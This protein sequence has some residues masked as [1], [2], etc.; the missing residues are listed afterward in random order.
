MSNSLFDYT[1]YKAYLKQII[2]HRGRGEK[3]RIS[4]AL[5]CHI[6]YVSQVLN[7]DANFSL[8][9]ADSLNTYLSHTE[10]ESEFFLLLVSYAR[11][12]STSLQKRY[13]NRI[14]KTL[15][16]RLILENRLKTKKYLPQEQQSTY[17]SAWYYSAVHLLISIP[18]FQ[19]K[20]KI[21]QHLS[22]PIDLVHRALTFLVENG[23]AQISKGRYQSGQVSLH[24]QN[25]SSWISQHHTSWRLQSVRSI[26]H[27]SSKNFHYTSVVSLS[28]QDAVR[29]RKLLLEAI[30]QIRPIV[31]ESPEENVYCYL[32]DLFEV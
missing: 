3:S 5:Q 19:T 2:S 17:Y 20:E 15:G 1:D 31:R 12:G 29:I 18:E 7:D 24:L 14:K 28:A 11:A 23:L 16:E 27:Q 4:V 25:Q 6:A 9:Q 13:E 10:D 22:L 26:E 21:A 32:L 30:E 8:E